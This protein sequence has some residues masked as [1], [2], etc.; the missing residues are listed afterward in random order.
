MPACLSPRRLGFPIGSRHLPGGVHHAPALRL[1]RYFGTSPALVNCRPTRAHR[2]RRKG[3]LTR[4]AP[5]RLP[6]ASLPAARPG[7]TPMEAADFGPRASDFGLPYGRRLLPSSSLTVDGGPSDAGHGGI[8]RTSNRRRLRFDY[9][10]R[11]VDS[12]PTRPGSAPKRWRPKRRLASV[13]EGPRRAA[14]CSAQR[15][16]SAPRP[17]WSGLR[18]PRQARRG[19][20]RGRRLTPGRLLQPVGQRR[21]PGRFLERLADAEHGGLVPGAADHLQAQRQAAGVEAGRDRERRAGRR[22]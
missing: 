2:C 8:S 12:A 11:K 15:L 10:L 21:E 22:G 19:R 3:Q 17:N 20:A 7:P 13:R 14:R 5:P 6:D 1:A 9:R 16:P 18:R 4:R